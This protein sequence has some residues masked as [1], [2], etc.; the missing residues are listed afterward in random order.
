MSNLVDANAVNKTVDA[1]ISVLNDRKGFDDWWDN[2]D[3][4]CER[5]I[6]E[7]IARKIEIAPGF[8]ECINQFSFEVHETAKEK[9]WWKIPKEAQKVIE[10]LENQNLP[11][12]AEYVQTLARRNNA[13]L[14]MLMVTEL[15][16]ACEG[17][18]ADDPPDDKIPSFS[19]AEAE[20]ADTVIRIADMCAAKGWRLG[21]AI[22]A[23]M[24]YNKGREIR[25]GGKVF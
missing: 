1:I 22:V 25:H 7:S 17:L 6:K 10:E 14:L 5:E 12:E 19:S 18:R 3:E 2:L 4:E 24:E 15:A 16:E 23:K 13:E 11:E 20:L 9:G 21:E 8:I